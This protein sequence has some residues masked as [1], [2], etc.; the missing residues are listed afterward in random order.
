MQHKLSDTTLDDVRSGKDIQGIPWEK[1]AITRET[2][3][4][5]RLE[6]YK[7]YENI[8][9]SGDEAMAV[10][11]YKCKTLTFVWE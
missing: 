4:Q 3:R 5:A 6:Q 1:M 7:N 9:D 11:W 2:Y 10:S 8:P